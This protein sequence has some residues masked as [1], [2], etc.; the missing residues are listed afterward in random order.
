[1][2]GKMYGLREASAILDISYMTLYRLVKQGKI[3]AVKIG[4]KLK[5]TDEELER[6]KREGA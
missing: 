1:V 2:S 4:A 5:I 3:R 6:V